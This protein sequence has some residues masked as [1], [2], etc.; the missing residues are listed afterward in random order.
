MH[1]FLQ[2][3]AGGGQGRVVAFLGNFRHASG[4]DKH[5]HAD[6]LREAISLNGRGTRQL[7]ADATGRT[8][9]TVGNWI[10]ETNPTLPTPEERAIIRR[11]LG[12]Y[13]AAGDQV[14]RAIEESPLVRWRRRDVLTTYERHLHEQQALGEVR[15]G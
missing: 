3:E 15:E 10:S 13:D 5:E 14:E 1:G 6:R 12:P 9:R 2:V 11:I 8:Y 4:M 7:I